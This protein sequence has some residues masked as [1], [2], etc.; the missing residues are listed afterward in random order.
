MPT[1][2]PKSIPV[3]V[4]LVA[5]ALLAGCGGGEGA[6]EVADATHLDMNAFETPSRGP[7]W[8][9]PPSEELVVPASGDTEKSQSV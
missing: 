6:D 4:L 2:L 1:H 8:L 3:L 9:N 7:E 5:A